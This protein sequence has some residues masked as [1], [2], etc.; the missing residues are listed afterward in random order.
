MK[1]FRTVPQQN[2]YLEECAITEGD[3]S[4]TMSRGVV[5]VFDEFKYQEIL[6]FGGAFTESSAYNYSLLND[7]VLW[8]YGAV[9]PVKTF[10]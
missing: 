10:F 8:D 9:M 3:R 1:L 6:G 4:K 5:N 2:K 7:V